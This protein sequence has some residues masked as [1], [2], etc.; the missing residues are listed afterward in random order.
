[1]Q[2]ILFMDQSK[3]VKQKIPIDERNSTNCVTYLHFHV[4]GNYDLYYTV[5][6]YRKPTVDALL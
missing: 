5:F 3:W 4:L 1:M 2:I 6:L